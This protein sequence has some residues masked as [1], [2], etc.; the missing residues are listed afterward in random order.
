M[1]KAY[2]SYFASYLLA[3][4]SDADSI[5]KIILFGSAAKGE[6][7][8]ESDMDI[9]IEIKKD[10]KRIAKII[11]NI[12]DKFYISR[13]ALYFKA[14]GIDNKINLIIGRLEEWRDLKKSIESTGMMLYGPY[15]S[16]GADGRKYSII[17]WD[18]IGENR[19]SF[20]NKIYGVRIKDKSYKGMMEKLQGRKIGKSAIMVPVESREEVI[21]LLKY[22][23]VNAK[24]TDVYA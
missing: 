8:K 16:Y 1:L 18:S 6:A 22:H 5:N 24:I 17:S 10:D 20:L 9:F 19:G 11:K 2:A 12:L 3:N 15:V 21:K 7:T 13:E 14:K 4:L 23:K